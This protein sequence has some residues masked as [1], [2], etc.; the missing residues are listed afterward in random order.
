MMPA[1]DSLSP[2]ERIVQA[3]TTCFRRWG[4]EKTSMSDIA[5]MAGMQR[6]QLYRHVESKDAL[7]VTTIVEAARKL[8]ERR[9]AELP[10]EGS[11]ADL[12]TESL[13]IGHEDLLADSFASHLIG[14]GAKT[15]LRLLGEEAE[16]RSSQALWWEPVIRYGQERGE[17]RDDLTVDEITDWFLIA[18]IGM[19]E[20]AER[21]PTLA[22]ARRHLVNFVV[23]AVL[24][25]SP[26]P[27]E[28]I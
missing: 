15:F 22:A 6:S 12:I 16:L 19:V 25:R 17:I 3:A 5:A 4:V 18:Q 9:L 7:I 24:T 11:A 20:Y 28:E 23:P 26:R 14:D 27:T 1:S 13:L 2:H 21:Y 10:L 8:S